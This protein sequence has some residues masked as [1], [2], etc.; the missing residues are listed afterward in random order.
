MK[1]KAEFFEF[2]DGFKFCGFN[3]FKSGLHIIRLSEE[4]LAY[5]Q[6]QYSKLDLFGCLV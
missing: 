3:F 2:F 6:R 5:C 1:K 4:S